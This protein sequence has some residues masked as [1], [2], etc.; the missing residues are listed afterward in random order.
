[1]LVT[2]G[3]RHFCELSPKTPLRK[4]ELGVHRSPFAVRRSGGSEFGVRSSGFGVRGSK[5]GVRSRKPSGSKRDLLQRKTVFSGVSD[6]HTSNRSHADTPAR[7]YAYTTF[8]FP[9][10]KRTGAEN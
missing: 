2:L 4:V 6:I 9:N 3:G 10:S 1:M 5:F 8:Q 7:R